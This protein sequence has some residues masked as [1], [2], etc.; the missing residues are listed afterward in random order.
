MGGDGRMIKSII[1]KLKC[2]LGNHDWITLE[3]E[4]SSDIDDELA[5]ESVH[6]TR[7]FDQSFENRLLQHRFCLY[8]K[9]HDDQI[10]ACRE[11]LIQRRNK[12]KIIAD[13]I[14]LKK[15]FEPSKPSKLPKPPPS[16]IKCKENEVIK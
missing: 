5:N 10:S 14:V 2:L 7:R 3:E 9:K 4:Y 13:Q 6:I 15:R 11:H 1:E 16:N 8:C 12:I